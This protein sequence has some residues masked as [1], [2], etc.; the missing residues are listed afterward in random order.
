MRSIVA[1]DDSVLFLGKQGENLATQIQFP[2]AEKWAELYGN[3]VFQLIFQ[4]PTETDPYACVVTID[5]ENVCWDITNTEVAIPGTGRVELCYFVGSTLA[6]SLSW[7]TKSIASL[8]DVGD[9]PPEPW[10]SWVEDVLQAGSEAQSS[11]EEARG[12]AE[13][14]EGYASE[15]ESARDE[16]VNAGT[17][18]SENAELAEA[19]AVGTKGGVPV[20]EEE[21][22]HENNAKYYAEMAEASVA[23]GQY[24]GFYIDDDGEL[25][26]VKTPESE[27]LDFRLNLDTGCLEVVF[28]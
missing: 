8:T 23:G 4:R 10:E 9:T 14:A 26:V 11:A 25:Y 13:D 28:L 24:F 19:W 12:Y 16:A 21:E 7:I 6:I 18:A 2:Y 22:Q 15:A 3:G 5:G 27:N 20:S 17:S 1:S